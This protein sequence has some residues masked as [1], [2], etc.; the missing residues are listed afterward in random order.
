[1]SFMNDFTLSNA[2]YV[3]LKFKRSGFRSQRTAGGVFL[4]KAFDG[5]SS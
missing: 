1:M 3:A 4:E 2:R 5:S